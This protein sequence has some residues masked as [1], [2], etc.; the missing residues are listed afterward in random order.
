MS[1]R[2]VCRPRRVEKHRVMSLFGS[3]VTDNMQYTTLVPATILRPHVG[4]FIL[5]LL[6]W[7][8]QRKDRSPHSSSA[9]TTTVKWLPTKYLHVIWEGHKKCCVIPK[10]GLQSCVTFLLNKNTFRHNVYRQWTNLRLVSTAQTP[11]LWNVSTDNCKR[12]VINR[13]TK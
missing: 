5:F 2:T 3:L 12:A 8:L 7:I 1:R 4:V 6:D 11:S 13:L 10:V 9:V